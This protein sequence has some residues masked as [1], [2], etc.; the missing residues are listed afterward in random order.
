MSNFTATPKPS[1][2]I[3]KFTTILK[4]YIANPVI[5]IGCCLCTN[6]LTVKRSNWIFIT[7]IFDFE[8]QSTDFH[9]QMIAQKSCKILPKLGTNL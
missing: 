2:A 9:L 6:A 5:Q 4:E 3:N 8:I 7:Q 1:L